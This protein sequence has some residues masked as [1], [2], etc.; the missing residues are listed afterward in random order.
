MNSAAS[1]ALLGSVGPSVK[2]SRTGGEM[3]AVTLMQGGRFAIK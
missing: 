3:Q 2:E 1:S